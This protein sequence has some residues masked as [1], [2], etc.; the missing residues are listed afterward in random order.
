MIIELSHATDFE[1]GTDVHLYIQD[2]YYEKLLNLNKSINRF[3]MV[4]AFVSKNTDGTY[5]YP[6]SISG[7][8]Y[9]M[10]ED[11]ILS[12]KMFRMKDI[13]AIEKWVKEHEKEWGEIIEE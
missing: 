5:Q 13:Q 10:G 1:S 7:T 12:Q 4:H 8:V 6:P 2:K 3:L 11:M 9:C